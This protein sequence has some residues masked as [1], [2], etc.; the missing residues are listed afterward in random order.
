LRSQEQEQ[1][2]CYTKYN[3]LKEYF[4]MLLNIKG[5]G[6]WYI[7]ITFSTLWPLPITRSFLFHNIS[8]NGLIF[9]FRWMKGS[10]VKFITADLVSETM[11]SRTAKNLT[12]SQIDVRGSVHHSTIYKEDPTGCNNVS[13]F[14]YT[15]FIWSSTCFGRHIAHHQKPTTALAASGFSNTEGCWTCSWWTVSDTVWE[16]AVQCVARNNLSFI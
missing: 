2:P 6:Q 9:V 14:Y 13:N 10:N 11:W 7:A 15:I 16:G 8:K 1:L 4:K 12:I 5:I 3:L